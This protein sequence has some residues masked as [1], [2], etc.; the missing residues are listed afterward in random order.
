MSI[1][2]HIRRFPFHLVLLP[3]FFVL[4]G[5]VANLPL[6]TV[7]DSLVLFLTYC[8]ASV[9]LSGFFYL[10][11]KDISKAAL[12]ATIALASN[13]FFG[14]IHDLLKSVLGNGFLT[15]Y[16][17]VIGVFVL[18]LVAAYLLI[19][20]RK[21][22]A[23]ATAY[24]SISLGLLTL[25]DICQF[26]F[27]RPGNAGNK[28]STLQPGLTLCDTCAKP[29]VYVVVLDEYAGQT[30][31]KQLYNYDN[32]SFLRSL[33]K[34]GFKNIPFS[35]SNYN[36]TPY[37]TAAL[38]NM[39]YLSPGKTAH[40]PK[41]FGYAVNRIDN[42]RVVNFFLASGYTFYNYSPF[43]VAGSSAP[44]KGSFVP[45]GKELINAGTFVS[46]FEKHVLV[47][48]AT[49]IN[50]SWYL[51]KKLYSTL[52][53][54]QRL[55][56]L[57]TKSTAE[58]SHPKIVYTHLLMPHYPYFF[59][60]TGK[61]LSFDEIQKTPMTDHAAYLQYLK[62]AN[63]E[64]L[65]LVDTIRSRSTRPP[66]IVIMSDHGYRHYPGIDTKLYFYNFQSV[67][68]PSRDYRLFPDTMSNVNFL[69]AVLNTEFG[70][71]LPFQKDS[72]FLIDF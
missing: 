51:K 53:D 14:N 45:K 10:L 19:K 66:V 41:G 24:L 21:S 70:Q 54:N 34:Y 33:E 55:Y 25:V 59:D 44:I 1:K 20:K 57:T 3:L 35:Q 65:R 50:W 13:F 64:V 52:H 28:Y 49:K 72:T 60:S 56:S 6:V 62:Y 15:R 7:V 11:Y 22:V 32:G 29:D 2:Q 12:M 63:N 8:L 67:L 68:L 17:A 61:A 69:K 58:Q 16:G 42:N 5:F 36:Y 30:E 38:L 26:I 39:E 48:L 18:F 9:V 23:A 43:T 27:T 31:L 71:S 46:R 4:H 37:S 47:N 40:V